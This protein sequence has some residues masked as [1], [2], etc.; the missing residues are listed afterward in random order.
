MPKFTDVRHHLGE[1]KYSA[2][3]R[4]SV[5][6]DLSVFSSGKLRDKSSEYCI[7]T[8]LTTVTYT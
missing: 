8:N 7:G 6:G 4:C 2:K 1:L 3:L 5:R